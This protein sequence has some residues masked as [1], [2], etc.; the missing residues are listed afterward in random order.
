MSQLASEASV[1]NQINTLQTQIDSVQS[2]LTQ[3]SSV[4]V[5]SQSSLQ[6]QLTGLYQQQSA[7]KTQLSQI[8]LVTAQSSSGGQ[9]VSPAVA[10]KVPSSPKIGRD[11]GIAIV[12]GL[13]VGIGF[14]LLRDNLD[15][16]VRGKGGLE[17]L[18]PGIPVLGLIPVI[19]EWH[20]RK[21]PFLVAQ[22]HPQL[23]AYRG[24]P[25]APHLRT[26]HGVGE[27]DQG[28]PDHQSFCR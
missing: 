19:N 5:G 14:A 21:K 17:Q 18:V 20:N 15:D 22:A 9:V 26:V 16:R 1:Q 12:A 28:P 23:A 7:L 6:S 13:L 11:I 8:Q 4:D 24:L 3:A 10:S 25:R 2:Q 27:S